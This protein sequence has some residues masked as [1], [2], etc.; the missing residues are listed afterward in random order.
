[1]AATPGA[2]V[3]TDFSG[4][5][6]LRAKAHADDPVALRAAAQQFEALFT[7]MML[8]SMRD[9]SLGDDLM[10]SEQGEFYRDMFDQQMALSLSSGK[11]LGLADMLVRQMQAGKAAPATPPAATPA[12]K[13]FIEQVLPH[14]QQAGAALGV[15]PRMLIA[16]SALETGW[17]NKVI[18]GTN[19]VFNIKAGK[20]WN[21]NRATVATQEFDHGKAHL[22]QAA[23]RAYRSVADSFAD[24][25]HKIGTDARYQGV[26]NSGEDAARFA[27][28]LQQAGY[29]TDPSYARKVQA[30]ADDPAFQ[31]RVRQAAQRLGI[32]A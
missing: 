2:P 11:G 6:A 4:Y 10:S 30:I 22:E 19:N 24:Y 9:A 8:K 3:V 26:R 17:G 31:E 21:G 1:M 25:A 23:F 18:P 15:A 32:E 16:Q 5:S 14:A 13:D 7:Q 12:K 20:A 29:A 28:G 27:Q